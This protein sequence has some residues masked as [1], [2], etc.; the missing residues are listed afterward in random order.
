MQDTEWYQDL[1]LNLEVPLGCLG[2]TINAMELML[3]GLEQVKAPYADGLYMLWDC[4][5]EAEEAL[6]RALSLEQ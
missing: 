3:L 6:H 2:G 1:L 5:R 4:L